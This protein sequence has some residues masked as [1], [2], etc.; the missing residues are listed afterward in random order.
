MKKLSLIFLL[1]SLSGCFYTCRVEYFHPSENMDR[2]IEFKNE[3]LSIQ[4]DF[5]SY[6]HGVL[7]GP[8]G[9]SKSVELDNIE[10]STHRTD[11]YGFEA[12]SSIEIFN[13]TKSSIIINNVE[14]N[15][16]YGANEELPSKFFIHNMRKYAGYDKQ[17]L[18][19]GIRGSKLAYSISEVLKFTNT[20]PI[21]GQMEIEYH[22][23]GIP[24]KI[25]EM[26]LNVR[27][28]YSYMGTNKSIVKIIDLKR[29]DKTSTSFSVGGV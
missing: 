2:G 24:S 10:V 22:Y 17:Y 16:L 27:I 29:H 6:Y 13:L 15:Y 11:K 9:I 21:L 25:L 26:R 8:H 20:I 3:D 28:E 14:F 1:A 23:D 19:D 12:D 18:P 5:I 7:G 4:V